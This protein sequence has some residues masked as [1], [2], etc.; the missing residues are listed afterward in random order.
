[1]SLVNRTKSAAFSGFK[2]NVLVPAS[3]ILGG[4][5][6]TTWS[7]GM[8]ASKLPVLKSN[9]VLDVL[10]V[11]LTAGL[12]GMA[13]RRFAP[14][15]AN[16]VLIGGALAAVTRAIRNFAPSI[17]PSSCLGDDMDGLSEDLDGLSDWMAS[18]RNIRNAFPLH[19]MSA[20]PGPS[21]PVIGMNDYAMN[22]Q[23]T[24]QALVQLD[25]MDAVGEEI[26]AQM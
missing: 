17:L 9:K 12:A 3:T 18:P 2:P 25:G 20:Y 13:T 5:I 15:Y 23:T 4:N 1:M 6:L 14:K 26:A 16:N 8:I 24:P 7:A 11:G 10:T 19:G 22:V 21:A